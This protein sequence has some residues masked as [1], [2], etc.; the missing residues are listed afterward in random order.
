MS[1][2]LTKGILF[3]IFLFIFL[4]ILLMLEERFVGSSG[5]SSIRL[6]FSP[7]S[8]QA[9]YD[10]LPRLIMISL[11]STLSGFTYLLYY[12]KKMKERNVPE[13]P[14]L[15][16]LLGLFFRKSDKKKNNKG[17]KHL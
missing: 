14:S 2:K 17:K 11:L 6:S 9:I 3:S 12:Q 13:G 10:R 1:S 15:K 16:D 5:R 4:L 7:K 8:W